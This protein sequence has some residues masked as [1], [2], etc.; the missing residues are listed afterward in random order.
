[1][2]KE[3]I[4]IVGNN[5]SSNALA[6]KLK[7]SEFCSEIFIAGNGDIESDFKTVDIRENNCEE[8]LKFVLDNGIS[9][10]IPF[11]AKS[12]NAGVGDFFNSNEQKV[13]S[14]DKS[15]SIPFLNG[16]HG[17]KLL[18]RI[19]SGTSKFGVFDK[20]NLANDFLDDC[21]FPVIV[22]TSDVCAD[23]VLCPTKKF[24]S[25]IIYNML[26]IQNVS[27]ILIEEYTFGHKFSVYFITDGYGVLPIT[28]FKE[29][30]FEKDSDCAMLTDG[31]GG[32]CPDYKI[33]EEIL[34]KTVEIAKNIINSLSKKN[35]VYMGFFGIEFNLDKDEILSAEEIFPFIRNHCAESVLNSTEVD[36][37]DLINACISGYFA[38]DYEI[39]KTNDLYYISVL[40][41]NKNN[42]KNI[43][44]CESA[45]TLNR[46]KNN[47]ILE[48]ETYKNYSYRK[49]ILK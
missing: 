7:E 29:Y 40:L 12:L 32:Y 47:L 2:K 23:K 1:M 36:L 10:T 4:L 18:Y 31:M 26:E 24:A 45:K 34:A 28:T 8:L 30:K 17:K 27:E 16:V 39:I 6:K 21:K 42:N 38:D 46:A 15:S 37:I 49:D 35:S 41:K 33:S 14:S 44:L 5:I 11:C 48:L 43:V 13:F 19:N 20:I 3:K 25:E 22:K 9:L